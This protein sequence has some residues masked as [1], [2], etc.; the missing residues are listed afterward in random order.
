MMEKPVEFESD[1]LLRGV[2]NVPDGAAAAAPGGCGGRSS[3]PGQTPTSR[4]ALAPRD[5]AAVVFAHGWSGYRCGP[6]RIFVNAARRFAEEGIA[7]LRFDF[8]GRGDSDGAAAATDLDAMI[9]DLLAAARFVRAETGIE[10]I[11]PLGLCSGGNVVLG[12]AA[13]ASLD[14]SFAGLVLWST[15][16]FAPQKPKSD[17]ARRRAFFVADYA[18]KLFRREAWAKLFRGKIDFRGVAR[19]IKGRQKSPGRNPKDSSRDVMTELAGYRGPAL[20]IYGSR[21]DEAIGAPETYAAFCS[22]HGIPAAFHTVDGANHSYYSVAWERKV[23]E[24]TLAWLR[25]R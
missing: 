6:H 23:I 19:T 3:L 5:A 24:T 12:A 20:F 22:E 25:E 14:R 9:A 7:S 11:F 8:R 17:R 15:P 13:A 10:R 16:L 2:L 18:K 4:R 21:D 1:V